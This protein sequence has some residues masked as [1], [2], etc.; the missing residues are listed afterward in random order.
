MLPGAHHAGR[1]DQHQML[2]VLGIPDMVDKQVLPGAHHAGRADEHQVLHV[3]GVLQ[4]VLRGQV[5]AQAV[6]HQHHAL[7]P[8]QPDRGP[9]ARQP[10]QE[11]LLG[12]LA[13]ARAPPRPPCARVTNPLL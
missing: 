11:E 3:L 6:P 1:A 12:V 7:A 8:L 10:A 5:A 13:V 9:P 2:H 4:R